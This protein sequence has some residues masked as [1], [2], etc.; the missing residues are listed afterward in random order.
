MIST[1]NEMTA[2]MTNGGS[3][4]AADLAWSDKVAHVAADALLRAKAIEAQQYNRA[5]DII[6]KEVYDVLARGDRPAS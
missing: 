6:A 4:R 1:H 2:N 3:L 5:I